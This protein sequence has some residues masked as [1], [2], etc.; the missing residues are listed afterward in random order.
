MASFF[1]SKKRI[2]SYSAAILL[3]TSEVSDENDGKTKAFFKYYAS[4]PLVYLVAP[5]SDDK[6]E[7]KYVY[8]NDQIMD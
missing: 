7:D 8:L 6:C 1:G 4:A 3:D 5:T 2:S